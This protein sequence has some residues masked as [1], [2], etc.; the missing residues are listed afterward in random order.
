MVHVSTE[1]P[2][3]AYKTENHREET[4]SMAT[5]IENN[6]K[7]VDRCGKCRDCEAQLAQPET[8]ITFYNHCN[9]QSY[10]RTGT[11]TTTVNG[12]SRID[13][14]AGLCDVCL[15]KKLRTKLEREQKQAETKDNGSPGFAAMTLCILGLFIAG[16]ALGIKATRVD[17]YGKPL[18]FISTTFYIWAT[19][20]LASLIG[21][22]IS[23][24]RWNRLCRE[25][26]A[27]INEDL[28]LDDTALLGK[29][30]IKDGIPFSKWAWNDGIMQLYKDH[31]KAGLA[32][33]SELLQMGSPEVIAKKMMIHQDVA[34]SLLNVARQT[35]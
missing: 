25:T 14:N 32:Y 29:Y 28:K 23:I 10:T 19:L 17:S 6:A 33:A 5:K 11:T 15:V 4:N 18:P 3:L 13:L 31:Q 1:P 16:L 8:I 20:G 9:S 34:E 2:S 27:R 30:S 21:L 26:A 24:V 7:V 12:I 35:E 22:P